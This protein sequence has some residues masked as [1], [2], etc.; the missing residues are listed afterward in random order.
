VVQKQLAEGQLGGRS[1]NER[2]AVGRISFVGGGAL[3]RS[4]S[5]R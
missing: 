1:I 2:R 4:I 3:E 5:G